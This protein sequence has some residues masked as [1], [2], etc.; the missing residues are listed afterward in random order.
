MPRDHVDDGRGHEE[1]RDLAR[2]AAG[3]EESLT[4]RLDCPKAA[5]ARSGHDAAAV[6]I[7]PFEIH[8]RIPHC[9]HAG[10]DAVVDELIQAAC[11]FDRH[12]LLD[13]EAAHRPA[14]A[15]RESRNVKASDRPDAALALQ[16][17]RPGIGYR[18]AHGTDQAETGYNNSAFAHETLGIGSVERGERAHRRAKTLRLCCVVR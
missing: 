4:R 18:P 10:G 8:A 3:I 7:E 16:N 5:D 2:I 13:V 12:V 15:R 1:W 11:L 9:L 17:R 14:K 6:A